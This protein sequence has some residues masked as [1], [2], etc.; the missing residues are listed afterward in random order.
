[1]S[2]AS[3][4][5]TRSGVH[6]RLRAVTSNDEP[7]LAD[8][9]RQVAPEDLRFRFL[10]GLSE[11]RHEQLAAMLAVDHRHAETLLGFE[12]SSGTLLAVAMLACDPALD[13][14][15]VAIS[16]R[17]DHKHKGIAWTM[18]E[19]VTRVAETLGVKSLVSIESHANREAIELERE[20]GFEVTDYPGDPTLVMV[21]RHLGSAAGTPRTDQHAS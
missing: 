11:V 19:H 16:V 2:D 5:V 21:K 13:T 18:L 6:L 20:M 3:I 7:L 4:S 9:F 1:M 10:T 15:E 17:A 8:F 14:G 12:E